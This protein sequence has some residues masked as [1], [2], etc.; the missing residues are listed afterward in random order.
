MVMYCYEN[1]FHPEDPSV[2][3]MFPANEVDLIGSSQLNIELE[4]DLKYV[5]IITTYYPESTGEYS[6]R[7]W[8]L[9]HRDQIKSL[10]LIK[11]SNS[12]VINDGM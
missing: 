6:V 5:L 7:G 3:R 1:I 9:S 11:D 12:K 4:V 8:L 10:L 2:N